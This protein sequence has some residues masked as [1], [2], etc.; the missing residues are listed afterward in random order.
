M[1]DGIEE[2]LLVLAERAVQAA[3][4]AGAQQAEACAGGERELKVGFQ[5]GDLGS[6]STSRETTLGLRVYVDGR[7]GFVTTNRGQDLGALA[8][9]AVAIA[10]CSPP[11]DFNGLPD[12][13]PVPSLAA[14][15]S[16]DLAELGPET[17]R[18]SVV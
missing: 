17:D 3:L 16:P 1:K 14:L 11:D 5:R 6:V 18:K 12:P 13:Q 7:L 4:A 10:R 15:V 9:E 8:A 2:E